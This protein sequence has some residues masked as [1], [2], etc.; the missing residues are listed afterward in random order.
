MNKQEFRAASVFFI[1][2][3][4]A[5]VFNYLFQVVAGRNLSATD[6]ADFNGWFANLAIFFMIGG[7]LQYAGN[8]WPARRSFIR[9]ALIMLNLVGTVGIFYW[10]T[11]PGLFTIDRAGLILFSSSI[12]GWLTGQMQIRSAFKL[13]SIAGIVVAGSKFAL[14]LVPITPAQSADRYALAVFA[15]FLPGLWLTT[16]YLWSAKDAPPPATAP[17]WTAPI[18]L[19]AA[20]AIFPQFDIALLSHTVGSADFATFVRA[21]I[22][23][24]A[25]YFLIFILAQ[26]LLPRQIQRQSPEIVGSFPR[27]FLSALAGSAIITLAAPYLS[28]LILGWS[29]AP[30]ASIVFLSS[31]QMSLMALLL[32]HVQ[33]SCARGRVRSAATALVLLFCEGA[34]QWFVRAPTEQYLLTMVALNLGMLSVFWRR[35][36]FSF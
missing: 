23:S 5:G 15:S 32:L 7:L 33:E 2:S 6:F 14:A 30:P 11:Q 19:A 29:E 16:S 12:F 34:L 17:K 4:G 18:M 22:F 25:I 26:W 21:S 3:V 13:M 27:I 1:S 20:V 8:F 9:L 31:L 35:P 10:I 36:R 24:R 28:A